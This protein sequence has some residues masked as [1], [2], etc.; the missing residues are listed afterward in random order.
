MIPKLLIITGSLFVLVIVLP[1]I[2]V[3]SSQRTLMP[4]DVTNDIN[5]DFLLSIS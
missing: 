1:V 5:A 2:Q 3:E 4:R